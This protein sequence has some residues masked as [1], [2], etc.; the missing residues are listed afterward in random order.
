MEQVSIPPGLQ[1]ELEKPFGGRGD[2]AFKLSNIAF[3]REGGELTL[4]A[5]VDITPDREHSERWLLSLE[6]SE[7]DAAA[8][9]QDETAEAHSWFAL[10]AKTNIIEWW[11]TR[12]TEPNMPLPPRRIG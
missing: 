11:H 3:S 10:M 2:P 4:S 7:F 9:H 5:T 6:F 12:K 1:M 8:A